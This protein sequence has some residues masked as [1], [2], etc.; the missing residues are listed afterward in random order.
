MK[1]GWAAWAHDLTEQLAKAS[2]SKKAIGLVLLIGRKS[3]GCGRR[4]SATVEIAWLAEKL[5][6]NIQSARRLVRRLLAANVLEEHEPERRLKPGERCLGVQFERLEEWRWERAGGARERQMSLFGAPPNNTPATNPQGSRDEPPGF[7]ATNPQ[8]SR[9]DCN[10]C[11]DSDLGIRKNRMKISEETD[12]VTDAIPAARGPAPTPATT[13]PSSKDPAGK[14]PPSASNDGAL[15]PPGFWENEA[16]RL[17]AEKRLRAAL[18]GGLEPC[19][20]EVAEEMHRSA[21]RAERELH[22]NPRRYVSG[23]IGRRDRVRE[24][25]A[26]FESRAAE[27]RAALEKPPPGPGPQGAPRPK[28]SPSGGAVLAEK[29]PDGRVVERRPQASAM[30]DCLAMLAGLGVDLGFGRAA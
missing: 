7:A 29:G 22:A 11:N 19:A 15:F 26:G 8:G 6:V 9:R 24:I 4:A 1:N 2:L 27:A 5:D 20:R 23:L 10:N 28:V 14:P 21:L 17:G 25:A 16:I 3:F 13:R 30:R 12:V 18:T